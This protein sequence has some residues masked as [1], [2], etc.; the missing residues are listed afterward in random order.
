MLL[1]KA[2]KSNIAAGIWF[3]T[4]VL[5]IAGSVGG[6]NAPEGNVWDNPSWLTVVVAVHMLSF[7]AALWLYAEAKGYPGALGVA[8]AF[9]Y[10]VGLIV[11]YLLR[12]K[13]EVEAINPPERQKQASRYWKAYLTALCAVLVMGVLGFGVRSVDMAYNVGY[14]FLPSLVVAAIAINVFGRGG[15]NRVAI[16]I[17]AAVWGAFILG[18]Y[19]SN[20]VALQERNETVDYFLD[21]VE[22][23]GEAQ[24]ETNPDGS[25][26]LI[27]ETFV[28]DPNASGTNAEAQKFMSIL[29]NESAALTNQYQLE[30]EEI[31]WAMILDPSRLESDRSFEK[32]RALLE[33]GKAV[34]EKYRALSR[35]LL[36]ESVQDIQQLDLSDRDKRG[37]EKGYREGIGRSILIHDQMWDLEAATYEEFEKLIEFFAVNPDSWWIED[38]QFVFQTQEQVD[39][40]DQYWANIDRIM[41]EQQRVQQTN[42][43]AQREKIRNR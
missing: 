12:D 13:H 23:F 35:A 29:L 9:L 30:L 17:F 1:E 26:K 14:F 43:E 2:R 20:R 28:P 42:L 21:Q 24:W 15:G 41:L 5:V 36:E 37:F 19:L 6:L 7:M 8:L 25:P 16:S 33:E 39:E 38:G 4:L 32:S 22:E 27:D 40:F 3:V 18:A 10:V 31:G 11:L 34:S